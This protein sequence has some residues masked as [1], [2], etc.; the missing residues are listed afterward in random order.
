MPPELRVF[1]Y[2]T[3]KRGFSNHERYCGGG[4]LDARSATVR[5]RLFKL[6]PVVPVICIPET[7]VLAEGSA[8]ILTDL[9]TQE[10]CESVLRSGDEGLE[11]APKGAWRAVHGDLLT[12]GDAERRLPL[13]DELE[14]FHP[15]GRSTYL[16][17]LVGARLQDGS[18]TCAWTYIAGFSTQDLEEYDGEEWFPDGDQRKEISRRNLK[19]LLCSFQ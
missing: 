10:K 7:D 8:S 12:F 1:V 5:G 3:L 9:E 14:E 2:G 17:V 16:R 13:L 6:A 18:R 4:L 11:K 15:E 19:S